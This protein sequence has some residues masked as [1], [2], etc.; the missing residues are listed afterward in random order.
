MPLAPNVDPGGPVPF[1]GALALCAV[2]LWGLGGLIRADRP[3]ARLLSGAAILT[4]GMVGLNF[5]FGLALPTAAAVLAAAAVVGIVLGLRSGRAGLALHPVLWLP[6]LVAV[7]VVWRGGLSYQPY[8]WDEFSAWLYWPREAFL[9]GDGAASTDWRSLGY[10]QGLVLASLFP[11]LLFDRFDDVRQLAFPLMLHLALLSLA[12][13]VVSDRGRGKLGLAPGAAS[14]LAWVVVLALLSV[15]AAWTLVPQLL[16]AEKPQIYL[17]AAIVLLLVEAGWDDARLRR[18]A[19]VIGLILAAGFLFKSGFLSMVPPVFLA[20]GWLGLRPGGGRRPDVIALGLAM[21]PVVL[22][23]VVWGMVKGTVR[24]GCLGDPLAVF[25]TS[26]S[27]GLP[28]DMALRLAAGI[29]DYLVVY[30]PWLSI[31][32]LLGLGL[33]LLGPARAGVLALA[34]MA[35]IYVA[36]LHVVYTT[37]LNPGEGQA[38]ASLPRYLRVPLRTVHFIGL[39]LLLLE[40]LAWLRGRWKAFDAAAGG[41]LAAIGLAAGGMALGA[42]QV[43]AVDRSLDNLASRS[44][45][46]DGGELQKR[47]AR[48]TEAVARHLTPDGR[49]WITMLAQGS[50]GEEF[51][52]ARY[53]AMGQRRGDS[54]NRFEV[55][56]EFAF[57]D[58]PLTPW[59]TV[60]PAESARDRLAA[61]DLLWPQRPFDPWLTE[62]L[63]PLID[64]RDCLAEPL[65]KVLIRG[66]DGRFSCRPLSMD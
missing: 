30:K 4:L 12:F 49:A 52:Y 1:L 6:V 45:E 40:S 25:S 58:R 33:A 14:A 53:Y 46:R 32:A 66:A 10:T 24:V 47:L 2:V 62:V 27:G 65:G 39:V 3:G 17:N 63:R 29:W 56:H 22:A 13:D 20:V 7:L 34:A 16:Q 35:V 50:S 23:V 43:R 54:V 57:A 18:N 19:V 21:V 11:N 61:A 64:D 28:A 15:E 41:R 38:L 51:T 31:L 60:M 26:G 9:R 55:A 5:G 36:S 44:H 37:C 59:T 8:S 48:E 42:W